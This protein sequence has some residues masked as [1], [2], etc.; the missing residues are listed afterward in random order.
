MTKLKTL[1]YLVLLPPLV[2]LWGCD[3][4][5]IPP[6]VAVTLP[7]PVPDKAELE[8]IYDAVSLEV[9]ATAYTSKAIETDSTPTVTAWGDTLR[10]GMKAIAVSR[11]LI[12]LGLSHNTKVTIDGLGG[13]YLVLDK[14]HRKWNRKIDI[15]MGLDRKKAIDWG[16]R[17]VTIHW[18]KWL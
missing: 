11:D 14:M 3:S 2:L 12:K 4:E 1:G 8:P 17:K 6:K 16:K 13:E 15:Y 9:M 5:K 10:P 7:I 18:I